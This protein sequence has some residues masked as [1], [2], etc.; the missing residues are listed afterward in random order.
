LFNTCV[1]FSSHEFQGEA[2]VF[3]VLP[4]RQMGSH[5]SSWDLTFVRSLLLFYFFV[6]SMTRKRKHVTTEEGEGEG[7]EEEE[8]EKQNRCL[9]S[10]FCCEYDV[11][12]FFFFPFFYERGST[13]PHPTRS[14]QM[15]NE[16]TVLRIPFAFLDFNFKTRRQTTCAITTT[17]YSV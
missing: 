14:L 16:K 9:S 13:S 11:C 4:G 7:E 12:F 6:W 10:H 8:E 3:S 1:R 5:R 15:I 17:F 2:R